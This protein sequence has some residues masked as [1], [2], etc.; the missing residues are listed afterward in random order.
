MVDDAVDNANKAICFVMRDDK[1]LVFV[2]GLHCPD[3]KEYVLS[4]LQLRVKESWT[5]DWLA[6]NHNMWDMYN[7]L[8]KAKDRAIEDY[9]PRKQKVS[10]SLWFGSQNC[11]ALQYL[12][13]FLSLS[14]YGDAELPMELVIDQLRL[15]LG[16][17]KFHAFSLDILFSLAAYKWEIDLEEVERLTGDTGDS[18]GTPPGLLPLNLSD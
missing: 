9:R 4:Q 13:R 12:C 16:V 14:Q 15:E 1:W 5:V 7:E 6:N 2:R 8:N 17:P 18:P 3:A 11:H 10:D